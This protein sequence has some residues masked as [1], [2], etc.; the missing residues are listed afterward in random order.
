MA[1]GCRWVVGDG[2]DPVGPQAPRVNPST[3]RA[4]TEQARPWLFVVTHILPSVLP[5]VALNERDPI[6]RSVDSCSKEVTDEP[7]EH[8]ITKSIVA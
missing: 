7:T 2:P 5:P 3:N 8:R 6:A 1:G 4:T